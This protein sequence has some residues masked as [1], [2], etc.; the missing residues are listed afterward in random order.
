MQ[1]DVNICIYKSESGQENPIHE[2]RCSLSLVWKCA[3]VADPTPWD[4]IGFV[5]LLISSDILYDFR[6]LFRSGQLLKA[7]RIESTL[8]AHIVLKKIN[9][10][11]L[12]ILLHFFTRDFISSAF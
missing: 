12:L 9:I 6:G 5:F 3:H 11:I 10:T 1:N 7:P 8:V 4:F 2:W